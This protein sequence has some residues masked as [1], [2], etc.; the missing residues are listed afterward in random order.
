[1]TSIPLATQIS[2][3]EIAILGR[4]NM[5]ARAIRKEI[6]WPPETLARAQSRVEILRAVLDTLRASEIGEKLS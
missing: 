6:K 4:E 5:I 2:E 3:I 1:M